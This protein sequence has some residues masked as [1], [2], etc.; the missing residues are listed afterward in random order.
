MNAQNHSQ[1]NEQGSVIIVIM[2]ILAVLTI[3]GMSTLDRTTVELQIVRNEATYRRNFYLAESAAIEG[4]QIMENQPL[5]QELNPDTTS[6]GWITDDVT[7]DRED[8]DAAVAASVGANEQLS[9]TVPNSGFAAAHQGVAQGES[10]DMTSSTKLHEWAV[11]GHY[12]SP[13]EGEALIEIG[14]RKRIQT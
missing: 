5:A 11:F 6:W 4:A 12:D 10:L 1:P 2:V 9:L 13:N 8:T 7:I 14:Y 3:A